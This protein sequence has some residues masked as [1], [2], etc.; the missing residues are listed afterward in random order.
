MKTYQTQDRD[1]ARA[2]LGLISESKWSAVLDEIQQAEQD[3][4]VNGTKGI[5]GAIRKCSRKLGESGGAFIGWLQ[6]LPDDAYGSVICGGLKLIINAA[7]RHRDICIEVFDAIGEIP[8]V[9]RAAEFSFTEYRSD[10]LNVRIATLYKDITLCLRGILDFYKERAPGRTK[11]VVRNA[12]KAVGKGPNYGKQIELEIATVRNSAGAVKQEADR[13]LHRRV[14][15]IR[16]NQEFQTRQT[17]EIKDQGTENLKLNKELKDQGEMSLKQSEKGLK[18]G[19]ES[20]NLMNRLYAGLKYQYQCQERR[21]EERDRK[22][23]EEYASMRQQLES[24]SRAVTPESVRRQGPSVQQVVRILASNPDVASQDQQYIL[25]EGEL[26]STNLQTQASAFMGSPK[27]Q[28]WLTS[29]TSSCLFAQVDSGDDNPISALS[30]VSSLLYQ[31]LQ[32]SEQTLPLHYVC[33]LHTDHYRDAFPGAQGMLQSLLVQLLVRSEY[34]N[35]SLDFVDRTLFQRLENADLVA[36][37]TFFEALVDQLP[38]STI[39]FVIVDGVSFYETQ[40]RVQGTCYAIGKLVEIAETAGRVMKLLV[41]C[42]GVSGYVR[43]GFH[44]DDVLWVAEAG[45][46]DGDG[47]TYDVEGFRG[48]TGDMFDGG[49]ID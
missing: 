6:M 20:L 18:Q 45:D 47:F 42:P 7:I 48:K 44:D 2:K 21:W 46:G 15:A 39:L 49:A 1:D 41:T 13:C 24:I 3:A 28:D 10:E 32:A 36:L 11:S 16:S 40:D 29:T 12:F 23:R 19:E 22:Q 26:F 30:F 9:I 43:K 14:G 35:F 25:Q 38:Q 37:C 5:L 33:G 34:E 31:T 27:L 4:T 8:E 17:A